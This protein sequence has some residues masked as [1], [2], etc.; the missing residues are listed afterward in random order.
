MIYNVYL[1]GFD[2]GSLGEGINQRL[3]KLIPK[4]KDEDTVN[5]WFPIT[6]LNTSYKIIAKALACRIKYISQKIVRLEQAIFL[7]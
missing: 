4:G 6:L 5:G 1:E 3:I 7:G 2:N